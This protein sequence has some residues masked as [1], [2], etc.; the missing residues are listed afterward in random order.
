M[1]D[2][3]TV[4][5]EKPNVVWI[6]LDACRPDHLSC[7]GYRRPTSP[8]LDQLAQGGALFERHF[9]QAPMTKL[10]VPSYFTGRFFPV[11][12]HSDETWELLSR[13]PGV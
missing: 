11:F 5:P 3:A 1:D 9:A 4:P 13:A 6:L 2:P 10:S 12:Y 7:Y 8:T